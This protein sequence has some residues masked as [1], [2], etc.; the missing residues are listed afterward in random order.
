MVGTPIAGRTRR[1]LEGLIGFFVN[2]LVLRGDLAA[3]RACASCWGGCGKRR[4]A[5]TPTRTS[6]SSGWWRSWRVERSLAHNPLVQ[7]VFALRTGPRARSLGDAA[8]EPLASGAGAA[9]RPGADADRGRGGPGRGLAY[10]T[11][12]FEAATAER[13][14][15]TSGSLLEAAVAGPGAPRCPSCS[16][17]ARRG[18][19]APAAGRPAAGVP[20]G[21]PASTS[22]SRAGAAHPRR[23]RRRLRGPG[24]HLRRAGKRAPAGSP[25]SCG[26]RAWGRKAAWGCAWTAA[27]RWWWPCWAC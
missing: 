18:R 23:A 22:C 2:T 12:L 11:D 14:A 19:A 1:E 27:R 25:A 10:R 7:V 8:L 24:A 16:L 15:G 9:V 6:P 3:T 13:L 26:P 4:W 21:P 17:L 20:G 5:R